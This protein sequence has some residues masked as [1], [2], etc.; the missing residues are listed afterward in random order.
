MANS[1]SLI[2]LI[3]SP[4]EGRTGSTLLMKLLGTSDAI[5]FDREYPYENRYL[6]Y[7]T[8]MVE[9]LGEPPASVAGWDVGQ[10]LEGPRNLIGPLPFKPGLLDASHLQQSATFHLWQAFSESVHATRGG[11]LTRYYAE[12]GWGSSL[13]LL[14]SAGISCDVINLVRDPRDVVASVRAFDNRRGYFGFGRVDGQSDEDYLR[15]L[16]QTMKR[17]LADMSARPAGPRTLLVRYEDL[18]SEL[19]N[20]ATRLGGW[21]GVDLSAERALRGSRDYRHHATTTTPTASI[22][23]WR[24][25]LSTDEV[26]QIQDALHDEMVHFGY[27]D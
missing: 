19:G 13:S 2:P 11:R 7:L 4:M 6:A 27:L 20:V 18:V 17:N 1:A 12:K 10:L 24:S 15:W 25:D 8:R 21:L 16:L 5:G 22:G 14:E 23:R 3:V 9:H 26:G